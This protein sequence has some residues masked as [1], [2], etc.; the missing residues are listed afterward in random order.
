MLTKDL[1]EVTK[2]KPN[3]RPRYRDVAEYRPVAERV[4]DV[5]ETGKTRGEIEEEVG[6]LETHDTFKLVRGLSKLL[7]RRSTFEQQAPA[8]PA[9]LRNAV[10][11]RGFVTTGEERRRVLEAV[12][13]E[14]GLTPTAVEDGLWADT[15]AEAVLTSEP[16]VDPASLLRQFNLSLTQTLLFDAVELSFTASDNYQEI[17]GLLKY[18]GLM[19][20]VDEDLTVTVDGPAS[21]FKQTRKYG[22]SLA[23]LLPSI[24][25]A[26]EWSVSARVE[27]EV[28]DETRIYEFALDSNRDELFPEQ[29]AVES[30]DS[31]VERDFAIR[32]DSLAEGWSVEREPTVLRAGNRVMIPDFSFVRERGDGEAEFYLE[33]I[34]FWTPEYLE[35]KL[36]KV[37]TVES[38]APMVLAV[39]ETL[40]CTTE[41]FDGA[42]VD[43][44]F[45]YA[46]SIP[47]KPVLDRLHEI[48]E[49][50]IERDLHVLRSEDI[51]V[52]I[53]EVTTLATMADRHGL[54]PQAVE[55][56]LEE[57]RP[58]VVSKDKYVPESVLESIEAEIDALD[59]PTMEDVGPILERYG[60][61]Q[62]VL[63]AI[64]YTVTYT[65]LDAADAA[66]EKTDR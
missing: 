18:L 54:E 36:E 8:P 35:E 22:T 4:I 25:K 17:F 9:D 58:G 31:E 33:V 14:F 65:S 60:V 3:I 40:N 26:E 55:R 10:F 47:V 2:R 50:Q 46:D 41:D 32:I 64:G 27:T 42:N 53:D 63:E 59:S 19:Y 15:E 66:V 12:A 51:D 30:F 48:D 21:L 23:K 16:T 56:Y 11:D 1:L 5:Y 6:D 45:F 24:M 44:V 49:R 20:V 13:D 52:P 28:G 34:G 37:R 61:A 57:T 7:E 43:Q 62:N 29:A 38:E 39:N